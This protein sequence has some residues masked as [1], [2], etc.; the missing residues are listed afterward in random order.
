MAEPENGN[1][2]QSDDILE[3]TVRFDK[4]TGQIN[5]V[6]CVNVLPYAVGLLETGLLMVKS[7][8]AKAQDA[9]RPRVLMPPPGLPRIV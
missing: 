9:A 8:W 1:A 4:R 3:I 5:L 6:G 7:Q 2:A